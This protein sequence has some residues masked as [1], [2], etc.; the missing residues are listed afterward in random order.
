[1]ASNGQMVFSILNMA[2]DFASLPI[3][4]KGSLG[5]QPLTKITSDASNKGGLS[6]SRDGSLVAYVAFMSWETGRIE[7]RVRNLATGHETIYASENFPAYANPQ[8]SPDGSMLAYVEVIG[9]KIFSFVGPPGSLPGRQIAEDG[10]VLGFFADT[11]QVLIRY[12]ASRLVR[13]NL[14]TGAQTELL[15]IA[16]G[17]VLDA[18]LSPD[19][20]WLVCVVAEPD[21]PIE[22]YIMPVGNAS[23]P[24]ETWLRIP[25]GCTYV[26]L[27]GLISRNSRTQR[28]FSPVWAADGDQLYYFSD[29][30]GHSCIWAQRLDPQTK[31]PQGAAYALY[32]FHRTETSAM[33]FGGQRMFLAGARDKLIVPDWTVTGN[34]WIAK[35][36]VNK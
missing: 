23:A 10:Q 29:R 32:H 25:T 4:P 27:L 9:G 15:T 35:I 8:I 11:K 20:R 19:D 26:N 13:Q 22:T 36:D 12:G 6:I 34:L 28:P 18:R 5:S 31:H 30:D 1:M 16:S 33:S 2:Q 21:R 3:P 17:G 7:I 24:P 14:S